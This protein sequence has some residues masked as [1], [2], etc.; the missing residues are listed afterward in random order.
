MLLGDG[1]VDGNSIVAPSGSIV[2]G[3]SAPELVPFLVRL[4]VAVLGLASS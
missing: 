2:V 1:D 4:Q 3:F